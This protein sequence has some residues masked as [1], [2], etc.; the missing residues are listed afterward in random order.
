[1]GKKTIGTGIP[2]IS[3]EEAR[4]R[5]PDYLFVFPWHYVESFKN[6]EMELLKSGTQLIVPLPYP[7]VVHA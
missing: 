3:E 5:K 7:Q 2:I 1:V 6:R 4:S